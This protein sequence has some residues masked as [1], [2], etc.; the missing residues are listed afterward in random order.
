MVCVP[1]LE[2][3]EDCLCDRSVIERGLKVVKCNTQDDLKSFTAVIVLAALKRVHHIAMN[4]YIKRLE[5]KR[6][7]LYELIGALKMAAKELFGEEGGMMTAGELSR[8]LQVPIPPKWPEGDRV[9]PLQIAVPV[10]YLFSVGIAPWSYYTVRG[11]TAIT[12]RAAAELFK[13]MLFSIADNIARIV[14][15]M[16]ELYRRKFLEDVELPYKPKS[17]QRSRTGSKE[18]GAPLPEV[19]SNLPP[20]IEKLIQDLQHGENLP[21]FARF[22]LA[23]F[24]VNAGWSVDQIVDLFRNAPDFD[25]K[26]TRYQVEHIAGKRGGGRRYVPPACERMRQEGLC[27]ANCGISNPI[28]WLRKR[29][30]ST[31]QS[32]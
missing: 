31:A 29:Q 26:V 10:W 32:S 24:L 15:D 16:A 19:S 11:Y 5:P 27:V 25:E 28:E 23:A 17:V 20:C 2:L 7:Q 8:T 14:N 1:K 12:R 22:A 6:L 3:V 21:H 18:H 4:D 30:G 9:E 13:R